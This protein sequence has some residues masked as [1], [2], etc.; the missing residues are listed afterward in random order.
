LSTRQYTVQFTEPEQVSIDYFLDNLHLNKAYRPENPGSPEATAQLQEMKDRYL[1]YRRGWRGIPEQAIERG[2][3]DEFYSQM[4]QPPQSIDVETAALCDLACPHCFRQYIVTPDKL[5][6]EELFRK[7]IDQAVELGIPSLKLNWRGEPLMQPL[8]PRF[9]EYAK[10]KGMLET[11]INTN[12]VTLDAAKARALVE[13]GLDMMIYSF[14]GGTAA[15]YEKMRVG[16]FKEN[17]FEDV[18]DNI[19]RFHAIREEMGSP[20]PRTRIQMV[21]TPDSMGEVDEFRHRFSP[22]VDDVLVKAYEERGWGLEVY[23]GEKREML[24]AKLAKRTKRKIKKIPQ[25]MVWERSEGE[26]LL[27]TGRLPC[28][29]LYQ[30]LMVAYDGG[31][32]MCCNDWGAEHPIGFVAETGFEDGMKDYESVLHRAQANGKGFELLGNIQMLVRTNHPEAKV[33]TLAEIWDS[34]ELNRVRK[35]HIDGRVNDIAACRKCTFMDTFRW[36]PL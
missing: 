36:E 27:S 3:H 11:V 16:R 34:E 35:S 12:A 23:S 7:V 15:T 32:Y 5:I 25:T 13:A 8:L 9:I 26:F 19:A 10:R 14:D 21:L 33:T 22:I 2:L 31:V 20:F 6:T 28:Q 17:L 1:A 30:R 4:K 18:F 24:L 29:Q